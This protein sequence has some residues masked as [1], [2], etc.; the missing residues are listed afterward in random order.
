MSTGHDGRT[1]SRASLA[2]GVRDRLTAI[3][4][5]ATLLRRR[6]RRGALDPEDADRRLAAID[7]HV[8]DV[9]GLVVQLADAGSP[10]RT[11]D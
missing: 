5:E 3:K 7:R 2:R 4:T 9:D 8:D 6:L 1:P 10:P 11:D